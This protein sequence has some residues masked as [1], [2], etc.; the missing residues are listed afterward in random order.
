MYLYSYRYLSHDPGCATGEGGAKTKHQDQV[1][2]GKLP[3]YHLQLLLVSQ[4]VVVPPGVVDLPDS[5]Q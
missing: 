3:V 4:P 5:R 1:G 2:L